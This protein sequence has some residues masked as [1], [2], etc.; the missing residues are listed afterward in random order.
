M[1]GRLEECDRLL[2][3]SPDAS[4]ERMSTMFR[5]KSAEGHAEPQLARECVLWLEVSS[6]RVSTGDWCVE[7]QSS[8]SYQKKHNSSTVTSKSVLFRS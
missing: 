4:T 8:Q 6:R 3:C 1:D 2:P 5:K 7:P